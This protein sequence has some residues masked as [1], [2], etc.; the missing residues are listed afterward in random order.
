MTSLPEVIDLVS[1]FLEDKSP[2][3]CASSG[4]RCSCHFSSYLVAGQAKIQVACYT[5]HKIFQTKVSHHEHP[6]RGLIIYFGAPHSYAWDTD[7]DTLLCED[8][9]SPSLPCLQVQSLSESFEKAVKL[10]NAEAT[11][12]AT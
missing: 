10:K 2:V 8:C 9:Y 4:T 3:A 6:R 11:D 12:H 7:R 5:C 1:C